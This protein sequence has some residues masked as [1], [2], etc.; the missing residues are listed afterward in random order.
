MRYRVI[1]FVLLVIAIFGFSLNQ[2]EISVLKYQLQMPAIVG[3]ALGFR[4][5]GSVDDGAF[6]LVWKVDKKWGM[7]TGQILGMSSI[8]SQYIE[9]GVIEWSKV[10]F[11]M[12]LLLRF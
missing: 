12:F 9:T 7:F 2:T 4:I 1:I 10:Y 8:V 3:N 6:G 11:D 5:V